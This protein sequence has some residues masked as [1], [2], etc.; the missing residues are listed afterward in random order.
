MADEKTARERVDA[1]FEDA[2]KV[3]E[4]SDPEFECDDGLFERL[5]QAIVEAVEDERERVRA[6]AEGLA[7]PGGFVRRP[8]VEHGW[9]SFRSMLRSMWRA[10]DAKR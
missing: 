6:Q 2:R 9:Q 7:M 1:A 10:E 4:R 5:E 3:V 8:W